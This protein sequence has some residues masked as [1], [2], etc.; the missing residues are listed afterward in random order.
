MMLF[1]PS[2]LNVNSLKC[3]SMNNK[4]RE[5]RP[6]IININSNE[7]LS[8]C[9]GSCN[10]INDP[11]AKMCVSDVAKN[12]NIKVFNLIAQTN[13]TRYI[14][15][16][17][18]CKRKCRLSVCNNKQ[19]WNNNKWRFEWKELIDKG[20]CDKGFI[21]NTSNYECKCNKSW[22]VGEHLDYKNCKGRKSLVY[23]LV[24]ERSENIDENKITNVNLNDYK[25]A[26]GSCAVCIVLFA[27][28]LIISIRISSVLIYFY[29]YLKN[30]NTGVVNINPNIE[31]TIY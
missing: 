15:L 9:S 4:E 14:K 23:K 21:W 10:N 31:T 19:H 1:S 13:E 8:L 17:E 20:I 25:D 16:H 7:P 3:V 12:L 11:Y 27:V 29:W 18:T 22:D 26:C 28:F 5:V 30:N 24:E 2:V 6:E